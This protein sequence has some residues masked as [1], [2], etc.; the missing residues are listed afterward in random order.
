MEEELSRRKGE[1]FIFNLDNGES[2]SD[3]LA[4]EGIAD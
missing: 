2:S 4:K 3:A 1:T